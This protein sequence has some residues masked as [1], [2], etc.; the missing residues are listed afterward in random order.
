MVRNLEKTPL[1]EEKKEASVAQ[2]L[3]SYDEQ[4]HE[5]SLLK[6]VKQGGRPSIPNDS[7]NADLL[8]LG[9]M[10]VSIDE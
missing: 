9:D 10:A 4:A 7:S 1:E 3:H 6:Q 5:R 8:Y 2:Q